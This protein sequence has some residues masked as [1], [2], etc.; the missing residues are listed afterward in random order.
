[1]R[2]TSRALL[3]AV[4]VALFY[5]PPSKLTRCPKTNKHLS[6]I[7]KVAD[8]PLSKFVLLFVSLYHKE[9]FLCAGNFGKSW[10]IRTNATLYANQATLVI[11]VYTTWFFRGCKSHSNSELVTKLLQTSETSHTYPGFRGLIKGFSNNHY[12]LPTCTEIRRTWF[13]P[14]CVKAVRFGIHDIIWI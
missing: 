11:R 8:F 4:V 13:V 2:I 10:V 1:M 6:H 3:G 14:Y 9:R 5:I 7:R 12:S